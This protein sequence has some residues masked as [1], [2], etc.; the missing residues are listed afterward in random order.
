MSASLMLLLFLLI[1]LILE[2]NL[3]FF[4]HYLFAFTH[5]S[6]TYYLRLCPLSISLLAYPS[7]LPTH[8]IH[9]GEV[10]S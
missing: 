2:S 7:S 9:H 4:P 1:H 5:E 10:N 8:I 3:S 6:S